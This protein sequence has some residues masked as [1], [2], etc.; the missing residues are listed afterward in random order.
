MLVVQFHTADGKTPDGE[1]VI[2]I[3]VLGAGAGDT[4][5]LS[6]DGKETRTLLS[7]ETTPVRWNVM[8][9]LD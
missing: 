3:D 2:A 7:S 1:P 9:I 4:V 8:G 5:I 6:S